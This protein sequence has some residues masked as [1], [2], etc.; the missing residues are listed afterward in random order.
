MPI[1][2]TVGKAADLR[3]ELQSLVVQAMGM[4]H[5]KTEA[6]TQFH[7]IMEKLT[8]IYRRYIQLWHE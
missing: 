4:E 1:T 2:V 5:S 8:K 6:T 7:R 3:R